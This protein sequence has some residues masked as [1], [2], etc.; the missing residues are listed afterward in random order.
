ML[1]RNVGSRLREE[2]EL[3]PVKLYSAIMLIAGAALFFYG[4]ANGQLK[5]ILCS[6]LFFGMG[7]LAHFRSR[8]GGNKVNGV[9]TPPA[10]RNPALDELKQLP[11]TATTMA[12]INSIPKLVPEINGMATEQTQRVGISDSLFF[13]C[14]FDLMLVGAFDQVM[15]FSG[16]DINIASLF[17]DAIVFEATGKCPSQPTAADMA[18]GQA[19]KHR[20]IQ[21]YALASKFFSSPV[22][23]ALFFGKEYAR[24]KGDEM[25][26]DMVARGFVMALIIKQTGVWETDRALSGRIPT[27]KEID[28]FAKKVNSLGKPDSL[29]S[30]SVLDCGK[31]NPAL[32][33]LKKHLQTAITAGL[34]AAVPDLAT[35]LYREAKKRTAELGIS[36]ASFAECIFDLELVGAFERAMIFAGDKNIASLFVDAVVLKATGKPPSA[37]SHEEIICHKTIEHRGI[38][39]YALAKKHSTTSLPDPGALLFIAE[40]MQAMGEMTPAYFIAGADSVLPIRRTGEWITEKALTGKSPTQEEMDALPKAIDAIGKVEL[41]KAK[42]H[43]RGGERSR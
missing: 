14:V 34:I 1:R 17:V 19:M 23:F 11:Q 25:N 43:G 39:K 8:P 6:F 37:P 16:G 18:N 32:D 10:E 5:A 29:D 33:E 40:Y 38:A 12:L 28:E 30:N 21:K 20:G 36:D 15:A 31:W 35:E 42:V 24:A 2:K 7:G 3:I 9:F 13:D 27:A 26:Q 22:P 41:L 4:I